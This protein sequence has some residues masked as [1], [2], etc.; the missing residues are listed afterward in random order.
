MPEDQ[1]PRIILASTSAYRKSLLNRLQIPFEAVNP[2]IEELLKPGED[3][4][5]LSLRLAHDKAIAVCEALDPL[6]P[7][8]VIGSDQVAHIGNQIFAK[9]GSFD[10]AAEQLN[11]CSGNWVSFTTA[12]SLIDQTGATKQAAECFR[13]KFRQINS[14]EITDYL[15]LDEP[16]DCA[17][18]IKA[19]SAGITLL[20]NTQGRDINTLL[21]LPL[22]LFQEMIAEFGYQLSTLR[23]QFN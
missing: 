21:G 6:S 2:G 22:M 19:E 9:P 7:Y 3:P 18:S 23:K 14:E 20:E 8:I 4:L 16:F 11:R 10:E 1:T 17:G 13:V 5:S 12:I 15:A